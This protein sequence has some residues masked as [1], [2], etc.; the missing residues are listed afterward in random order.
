MNRRRAMLGLTLACLALPGALAREVPPPPSVRMAVPALDA[1]PGLPPLPDRSPRNANYTIRARLDADRHV[2]DGSL[3]LEWTNTTGLPQSSFPFHVYWNAFRNNLS[4]SARGTGRRAAGRGN[5]PRR[6]G[7]THVRRI[8][9]AGTEAAEADLTPTIRYI[10]PDDANADDRTVL[11]VT[12]PAPV[13]AGAIVRFLVD[14]QSLI[15]HGALGRAGWVHD[16]HFI[17]QWFPKIGVFWKGSWNAHQFHPTTEFFSDFGVYDVALTVPAGYVVGATGALRETRDEADGARTWRFYQ[18]DVHDFTWTASRRFLEKKGR[19]EASGYPPV[20]IRLLVQPEHEHLAERYI[21]ATRVALKGYGAWSAPYPYAQITVVDPAWG[22]GSGGMEYPTL[23]T[24]GTSI[25]APPELYSPESV[26]IHEAGHQFWYGLV[27]TN[28]FEEPWLDEGFNRYHD[29]KAY[30]LGYGPRGWGKRYFGLP[31]RSSSGWPVVAPGVDEGRGEDIR[32]TLRRHGR[33]DVMARRS[34]DFIDP[35][36]YGLNAYG[37]PALSLQTLEG[38]VGDAAMTRILRSYARR[39]RFAHPSSEDF[40]A[41]VNEVTGQDWR[42]YFDQTWFSAEECDYAVNVKNARVRAP[43]GYADGP[44]GPVPVPGRDGEGEG[45]DDSGPFDAEVTVLRLGG[46]RLP[47]EVR[48]DFADG[49][50]VRESWDGQYRWARF[51]YRGGARVTAAMVDPEGRIAL[52]VNPAN[53]GWVDEPGH[54]NRAA[55][56]WAAR[57]MFW[58]QHLL[59]MHAVLG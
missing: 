59:E 29:R 10:Q 4:T 31:G 56:K 7:Y 18:E 53:N 20:D 6:W 5:D 43:Q 17:A 9:L 8:A 55:T 54:A 19:F 25:W 13:P 16:Y 15:P 45:E 34:W 30:A 50:S 37:K 39:H 47:V 35:D 46:V 48:V 1:D 28:E 12:S 40:I 52:D 33:S 22:S 14:W 32:S 36:A 38:L 51:R 27:A 3:V 2:I 44:G 24:G 21:E 11:E 58:F 49:R 41:A 57:W 42:W 26:T 23:I